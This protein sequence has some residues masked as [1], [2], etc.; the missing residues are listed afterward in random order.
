[1]VNLNLVR[2]AGPDLPGDMSGTGLQLRSHFPGTGGWFHTIVPA[3]MQNP[4]LPE[5]IASLTESPST[6]EKVASVDAR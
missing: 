6:S 4:G 2:R 5:V 3:K 1:M